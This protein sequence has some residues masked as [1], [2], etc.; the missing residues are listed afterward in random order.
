MA[1][2]QYRTPGSD[3]FPLLLT[4]HHS[5][6]MAVGMPDVPL[7]IHRFH[8]LRGE[9]HNVGEPGGVDVA[10]YVWVKDL[11]DEAAVASAQDVVH[12]EAGQLAGE[13]IIY[14]TS[15]SGISRITPP[16]TFLGFQ[17]AKH[18]KE[19][20]SNK[21]ILEGWLRWRVRGPRNLN[22]DLP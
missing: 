5:Q 13:I 3:E 1:I 16:A 18:F 20:Q 6:L 12:R 19:G 10:C 2:S 8:R 11:A 22:V 14:S 17:Y 9:I 7:V 4:D 21:F 15:V